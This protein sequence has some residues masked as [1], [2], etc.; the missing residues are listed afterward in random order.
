MLRIQRSTTRRT[1]PRSPPAACTSNW[2]A[3]GSI[4]IDVDGGAESEV[5]NNA[6][7]RLARGLGVASTA[8]ADNNARPHRRDGAEPISERAR[9][10]VGVTAA[11]V[12]HGDPAAELARAAADAD[13]LSSACVTAATPRASSSTTSAAG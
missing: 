7:A 5:A 1:P 6:A 2:S 8:V 4:V 3:I 12:R 11:E 9:E 10:H 13:K